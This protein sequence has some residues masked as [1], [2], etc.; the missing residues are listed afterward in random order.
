[1]RGSLSLSS[2]VLAV[3]V[4]ALNVLENALMTLTATAN[5]TSIIVGYHHCVHRVLGRHIGDLDLAAQLIHLDVAEKLLG[6]WVHLI[7]RWR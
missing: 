5:V 1:M 6:R 2:C 4:E 3:S 7:G